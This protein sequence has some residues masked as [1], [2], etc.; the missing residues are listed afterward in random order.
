MTELRVPLFR[1]AD[2]RNLN[3]GSKKPAF[4]SVRIIIDHDDLIYVE[5][6]GS[7]RDVIGYQDT[8]TGLFHV[9]LNAADEGV[10]LPHNEFRRTACQYAQ[11]QVDAK[12]LELKQLQ[13]DDPEG[14]KKQYKPLSQIE[15]ELDYELEDRQD[16]YSDLDK[17][18]AQVHSN[19]LPTTINDRILYKDDSIDDF[20]KRVHRGGAVIRHLA[21]GRVPYLNPARHHLEPEQR[22]LV[23]DF[24][25]VFVDS[26]NKQILSWYLGAML[27]NLPVLIMSLA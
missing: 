11:D 21:T 3:A 10:P 18:L 27:L 25:D 15:R 13:A 12:L 8:Q 20:S 19:I 1:T 23:D 7:A 24:L 14:Y 16:F 17:Q 26:S 5:K 4:V 22:Q 2:F 9:K 6:T